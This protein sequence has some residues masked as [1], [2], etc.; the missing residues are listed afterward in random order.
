MVRMTGRKKSGV[1]IRGMDREKVIIA[2]ITF[3]SEQGN[4]E[5]KSGT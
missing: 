3:S 4:F 5:N 1:G 2:K